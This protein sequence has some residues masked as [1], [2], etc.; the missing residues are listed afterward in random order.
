LSSI[1]TLSQS[2]PARQQSIETFC[3]ITLAKGLFLFAAKG[4]EAMLLLIVL[5]ETLLSPMTFH[6]LFEY[7]NPNL[8]GRAQSAYFSRKGANEKN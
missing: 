4:V 3:G 6:L 1:R 7:L 2:A 5:V 8:Y